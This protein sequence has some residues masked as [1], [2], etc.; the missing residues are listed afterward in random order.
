LLKRTIVVAS[1]NPV[2]IR[3]ALGGFSRM[4]PELT[5]DALG[6][7]TASGVSDQ[8][9]S[10][11]ETLRGAQNRV[12]AA[13]L[14]EPNAH[15]WVGIE[16]GL[17]KIGDGWAAFAWVVVR[18]PEREGKSRTGSFF[19]P[20]EV[21][22]LIRTGMEMGEADDVV[23]GRS[24]SKQGSGASGI[25]TGDVIDRTSLYEH[26]IIL[27]LIPFRNESVYPAEE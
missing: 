22:R 15:F 1:R 6:K 4:F 9:M 2:K 18:C 25:L 16:G 12:Q 14:A 13:R 5:F 10:S 8:P 27:A 24:N 7:A 19:L 17:E 26:A 21:I 3:S 11:E 23:F 20:P